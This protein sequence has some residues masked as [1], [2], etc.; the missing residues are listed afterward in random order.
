MSKTSIK[1]ATAAL[2]FPGAKLKQGI[3]VVG[4]GR[5]ASSKPPFANL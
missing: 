2:E 3:M 5:L 4:S 1:K